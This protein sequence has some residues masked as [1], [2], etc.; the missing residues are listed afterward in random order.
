MRDKLRGLRRCVSSTRDLSKPDKDTQNNDTRRRRSNDLD[1]QDNPDFDME[2]R[3]D[4]VTLMT[5][6]ESVVTS[7][8]SS[9]RQQQLMVKC[10]KLLTQKHFLEVI[11]SDQV[12]IKDGYSECKILVQLIKVSNLEIMAVRN[13]I[14]GLLLLIYYNQNFM[15]LI[16]LVV[17]ESRLGLESRLKSVFAGLGLGLG[18]GL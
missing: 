6:S 14:T 12:M 18:L 13:R 5:S 9:D 1:L 3:C 17:L 10:V 16:R 4:D 2:D 8:M 11:S 15:M 7:A